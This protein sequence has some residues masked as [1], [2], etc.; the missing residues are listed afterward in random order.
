MLHMCSF[1]VAEKQTIVRKRK[2]RISGEF[3]KKKI[4]H[5]TKD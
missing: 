5:Y 4:I 1:A 2:R 3:A